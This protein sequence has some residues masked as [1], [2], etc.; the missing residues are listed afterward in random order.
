MSALNFG[1]ALVDVLGN[2]FSSKTKTTY[3][4]TR[5]VDSKM[6]DKMNVFYLGNGVGHFGEIVGEERDHR[7]DYVTDLRLLVSR[8]LTLQT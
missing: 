2:R 5:I 6:T 4:Q 3:V 1:H 7:I 8:P